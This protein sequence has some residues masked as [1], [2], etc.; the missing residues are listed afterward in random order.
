MKHSILLGLLALLVLGLVTGLTLS[1]R[2]VEPGPAPN[3]ESFTGTV[4]HW[5]LD[6]DGSLWIRLDGTGPQADQNTWFASPPDTNDELDLGQMLLDILLTLELAPEA[7][8]LTLIA[9]RERGLDGK[10]RE[11]ALPLVALTL[12]N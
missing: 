11:S 10:S 9:K 8:K 3:P 2:A 4:G 1:S 5:R 7:P 12:G 6:V